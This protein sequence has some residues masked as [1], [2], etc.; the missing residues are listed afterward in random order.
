[1]LVSPS[2]LGFLGMGN[3]LSFDPRS[4]LG[5]YYDVTLSESNDDVL[6]D[7]IVEEDVNT[8]YVRANIHTELTADIELRGNFGV[9]YITTEQSSPGFNPNSAATP[10]PT[11]I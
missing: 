10:A 1:M 7:Y 2:S 3:V 4:L 6:K 8:G 5:T 9:Q 11:P